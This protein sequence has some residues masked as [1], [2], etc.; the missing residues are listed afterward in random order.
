MIE[1]HTAADLINDAEEKHPYND[2]Y[3]LDI[4]KTEIGGR[5]FRFGEEFSVGRPCGGLQST[6]TIPTKPAIK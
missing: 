4:I 2:A 1:Y 5:V 3:F 6:I